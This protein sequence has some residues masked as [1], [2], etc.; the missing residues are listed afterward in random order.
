[1]E[2]KKNKTIETEQIN[3]YLRIRGEQYIE[4]VKAGLKSNPEEEFYSNIMEIVSLMDYC[5]IEVT[6]KNYSLLDVIRK[7]HWNKNNPRAYTGI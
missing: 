3:E 7:I 5:Y 1:M 4:K 6:I 2:K